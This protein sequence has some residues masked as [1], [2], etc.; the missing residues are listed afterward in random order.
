MSVLTTDILATI[1]K[2]LA[3]LEEEIARLDAQRANLV[4]TC[5]YLKGTAKYY[6]AS[7]NL[8][9]TRKL[10]DV[11]YRKMS[12]EGKPLHRT[13]LFE[14]LQ[15]EGIQVGGVRPINNMTAHMSLDDRFE[16]V[17]DGRWGLVEWRQDENKEGNS[18]PGLN[19]LRD[20][21]PEGEAARRGHHLEEARAH[22]ALKR[23]M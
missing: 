6:A 7:V 12:E 20:P 19:P 16:S 14:F 5:N 17:G 9:S 10:V 4:T 8:G 1:R 22:E 13:E 21:S 11:M 18:R 3:K 23:R 15:S 2:D